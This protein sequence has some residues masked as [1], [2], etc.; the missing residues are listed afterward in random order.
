[1]PTMTPIQITKIKTTINFD[2]ERYKLAGIA[3]YKR[4][5]LQ[6][7]SEVQPMGH[8]TAVCP[9]KDYFVEYDDLKEKSIFLN[10]NEKIIFGIIV[11]VKE[12]DEK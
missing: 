2:N 8:Y 10:K 4:P 12:N 11:Y 3:K 5:H 1:M 6:R 7:R 9:I